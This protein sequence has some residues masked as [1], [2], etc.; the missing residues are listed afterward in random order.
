MITNTKT[1]P[2]QTLQAV[3]VIKRDGTK[4]PFYAYKLDLIMHALHADIATQQVVYQ[5]LLDVLAS[6]NQV[7]TRDIAQAMVDGFRKADHEEMA[8]AFID[9]KSVV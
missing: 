3:K 4:T 7:S 1:E 2:L 9:R 8:E 6:A 5:H